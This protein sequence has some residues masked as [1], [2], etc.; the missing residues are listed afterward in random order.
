MNTLDQAEFLVEYYNHLDSRAA[1]YQ[2][3]LSA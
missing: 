2:Q 3:W 1:I